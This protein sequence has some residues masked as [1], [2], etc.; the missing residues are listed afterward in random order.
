MKQ[1]QPK[2]AILIIIYNGQI[3]RYNFSVQPLAG[4]QSLTTEKGLL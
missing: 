1:K 4:K 3:E 2:N